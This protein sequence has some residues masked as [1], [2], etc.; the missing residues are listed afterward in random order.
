[1]M[2]TTV[3]R[4][5]KRRPG[6]PA[7]REGEQP[8]PGVTIRLP[9]AVRDGL[10]AL[11]KTRNTSVSDVVREAMPGIGWYST[12][13]G[14]RALLILEQIVALSTTIH[15]GYSEFAPDKGEPDE[16]NTLPVMRFGTA[17]T[18]RYVHAV[19]QCENETRNEAIQN[20]AR[21]VWGVLAV[22]SS[23]KQRDEELK[24]LRDD[25]VHVFVIG[26]V[27]LSKW[28]T[29]PS[30]LELEHYERTN[31]RKTGIQ[32]T[33]DAERR[34]YDHYAGW[35]DALLLDV[36]K[37]TDTTAKQPGRWLLFDGP[38]QR[39][40]RGDNVTNEGTVNAGLVAIMNGSSVAWSAPDWA[41]FAAFWF[42]FRWY[43]DETP[44]EGV[45]RWARQMTGA[46]VEWL[47]AYK[48]EPTLFTELTPERFIAEMRN[49][50]YAVTSLRW[51]T[52]TRKT[53][54]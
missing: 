26:Y 10:K 44:D 34:V 19:R 8:D 20:Y 54:T 9:K 47:S 28:Q 22:M 3:Q 42:E 14:Q 16:W 23:N 41:T 38:H 30:A 25:A 45:Q 50:G 12:E 27:G 43:P 29:F 36:A 49:H 15:K 6:R 37:P 1:M 18:P 32:P 46:Y 4:T 11:A 48:D 39:E 53:T 7:L 17:E 40:L 33:N 2:A 52:P 21:K 35:F 5:E 51:L 24:A 31:P 13:H